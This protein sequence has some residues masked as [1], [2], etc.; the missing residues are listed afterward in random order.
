[1]NDTTDNLPGAEFELASN[2]ES[3][4]NIISVVEE[5]LHVG[6]K[7]VETGTVRIS[8]TIHTEESLV[9]A[10]LVHDEV[11]VERVPMNTYIET[12][13]EVRYEGDLMIIPVVQEVVV[14][15][16]RLM[17]VEEIRV[18]KRQLE[19]TV[20]QTVSLRKEEIEV[21]RTENPDQTGENT[22]S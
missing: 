5:Q 19:T 9:E 6:K 15:E 21:T 14:I 18:L 7:V 22:L 2:L 12:A 4:K 10:P 20:S 13:P 1:M 11:S 16:K 3:Q 8:K 17:L